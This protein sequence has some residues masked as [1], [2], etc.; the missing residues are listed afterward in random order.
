M[1]IIKSK[2]IN[3]WLS[4][5][6]SHKSLL[7]IHYDVSDLKRNSYELNLL[8]IC[9]SLNVVKQKHSLIKSTFNIFV[10]WIIFPNQLHREKG[11]KKNL[12]F[13]NASMCC[14][15]IYW[16][17]REVL[18]VQLFPRFLTTVTLIFTAKS[19]NRNSNLALLTYTKIPG[20]LLADRNRFSTLI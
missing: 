3:A 10:C 7:V 15:C 18:Y 19:Q 20:Y 6:L 14:E 11:K 17:L 9:I 16:V 5:L 1:Q 8:N 12:L 2:Q 4:G 13:H